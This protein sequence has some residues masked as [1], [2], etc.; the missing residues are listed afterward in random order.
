MSLATRQLI[1]STSGRLVSA[2]WRQIDTRTI[3]ML[4]WDGSCELE[5]VYL[6]MGEAMMILPS[7]VEVA[8]N[9]VGGG[10]FVDG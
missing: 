1:L 7:V 9:M 6:Q 4:I 2:S 3:S 5:Q 8:G 10:V